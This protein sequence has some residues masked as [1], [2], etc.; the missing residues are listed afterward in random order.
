MKRTGKWFYLAGRWIDQNQLNRR[1]TVVT[2]WGSGC[3][4][5]ITAEIWLF[6]FFLCLFLAL[7]LPL[8]GLGSSDLWFVYKTVFRFV[9]SI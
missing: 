4:F 2:G 5:R 3:Y 1:G 7:G 6:R 8:H 9:G